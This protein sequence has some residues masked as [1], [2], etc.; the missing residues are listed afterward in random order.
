MCVWGEVEKIARSNS[1]HLQLNS[2]QHGPAWLSVILCLLSGRVPAL[3][4]SI[5]SITL[6]APSQGKILTSEVPQS[7]CTAGGMGVMWRADCAMS[8]GLIY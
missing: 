3:L 1:Q 4:P 7:A 6:M 2:A 5:Y 8:S